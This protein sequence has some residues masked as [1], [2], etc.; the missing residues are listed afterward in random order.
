MKK[1]FVNTV[2]ILALFVV[3]M[4]LIGGSNVRGQSSLTSDTIIYGTGRLQSYVEPTHVWDSASYNVI[5]QVAEALFNYDLTDP[6]LP[7]VP[8]LATSLGTWSNNDLTLTIP[9]KQGV[10]FH[11]GLPFNATAAKWNFD[12]LICFVENEIGVSTELYR[13]IDWVPVLNSC[14]ILGDYEIE[15]HLN[16]KLAFFRD[17]VS[18]AACYQ[19]A[20][21]FTSQVW[22]DSRYIAGEMEAGTD[23]IVGT[24][25]FTYGTFTSGESMTFTAYADYHGTPASFTTLIFREFSDDDT[26]NVAFLASEYHINAGPN[27]EYLD[28]ID[29]S[30]DHVLYDGPDSASVAYLGMNCKQIPL[31]WRKIISYA[32]NYTYFIEEIMEGWATRLYSHIPKG[33]KYYNY[34]F[35]AAVQLP[36]QT[37]RQ[38]LVDDGYTDG[39]EYNT[40]SAIDRGYST[41]DL[42]DVTDD[43]AWENALIR[44]PLAT[45]NFTYNTDNNVRRDSGVMLQQFLGEIGVTLNMIGIT[46]DDYVSRLYGIRGHS[47]DELSIYHIGWIPDYNDPSNFVNPFWVPGTAGNTEQV[48]NTELTA[49]MTLGLQE[50]DEVA[51][52]AIYDEIQQLVIEEIVPWVFLSVSSNPDAW[53]L[54]ISGFPSNPFGRIYLKDIVYVPPVAGGAIPGYPMAMILTF[55]ASAVALVM[56]RIKKRH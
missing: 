46:W 32:Y 31:Y 41:T 16:Y 52:E 53:V 22:N 38:M 48:N 2:L 39:P 23:I 49:L 20:P 36:T 35:D 55:F 11:N 4:I 30:P 18:F 27:P 21:T 37:I 3:P 47:H 40:Q 26:R 44:A 43:G 45:F 14:V 6:D 29:A 25:P 28:D 50:T 9:L 15:L 51:R 17:L 1:K 34:D 19:I 33:I 13:P 24:G 56:Y 54:G 7:L 10:T 5:D 42:A 12:R 8:I